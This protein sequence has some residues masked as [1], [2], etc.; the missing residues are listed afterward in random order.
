MNYHQYL[1]IFLITH[2]LLRVSPI[3]SLN[4]NTDQKSNKC[5]LES[6]MWLKDWED[7]EFQIHYKYAK[8]LVD[9]INDL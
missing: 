8:I 7:R 3:D 6:L 5:I 4:I 1:I 2:D 9:Q